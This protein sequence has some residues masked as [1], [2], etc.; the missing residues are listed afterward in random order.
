MMGGRLL[1]WLRGLREATSREAEMM[2]CIVRK[3]DE[4]PSPEPPPDPIAELARIV[5]ESPADD[6]HRQSTARRLRRRE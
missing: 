3:S 6:R 2:N 1:E 5:G 4:R